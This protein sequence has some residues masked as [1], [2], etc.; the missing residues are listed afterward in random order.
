MIKLHN[1]ARSEESELAI[2]IKTNCT[3]GSQQCR[4]A[5]AEYCLNWT[6]LYLVLFESASRVLVISWLPTTLQAMHGCNGVS[7][8]P[9]WS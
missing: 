3:N 2:S 8:R 5:G 9:N 4:Q 1:V 7:R 6:I